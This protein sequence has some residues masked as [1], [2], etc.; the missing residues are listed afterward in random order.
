MTA[1]PLISAPNPLP[2][3]NRAAVLEDPGFGN[4][5]TDYMATASWSVQDGWHDQKVGPLEAFS[6]H[7]ATSVLH[8]A[9][10]IF[11][12][13]KAYRHADGSVW[14][15]RPE[16]NAARFA[17][18][19]ARLSLPVLD[20]G[21]FLDAVTELVRADH[22]WVP[23]HG[24]EHSLYIRPFMFASEPFLGVRAAAKAKFCVIASPAGPYFP[25]GPTGISLWASRTQTRAAEGG[26]GAAK[27]GGNYATG[28]AAQAEARA[29]GCD[30]VLYLDAVEHEWLEE[31][32]T[33]NLFLITAG[34]ELITP[35]L[36]TI[37]EGVTR[38]SILALA[39]EHG[40]TPVERRIGLREVL[41]RCPEGSITEI[42]ASGTAA[43]ITPIVSIQGEDL[44]V[45]VGSGA[46]GPNTLAIREHL[47][48]LQY[49]HRPDSRGWLRRVL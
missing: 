42:F 24:K 39:E 17:R 10:E 43:A 48:G 11:E 25:D 26:T 49:G 19:A 16:A 4:H 7:P 28:L 44:D 8:Y 1:V 6:L 31:S 2:H 32:G 22:A 35:G 21:L 41:T 5:F 38:D 40:L 14:L 15:F 45:T 33:M 9:Q 23:Q 37:L 29:H 34:R 13:L 47:L 18:S 30:Q 3:H 46:P 20:E 36:G 12:G 27:C